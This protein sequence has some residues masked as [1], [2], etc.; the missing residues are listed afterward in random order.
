MLETSEINV[1][2]LLLFQ[3]GAVI[4]G[5]VAE[6]VRALL[7][8]RGLPHPLVW[9]Q[10]F[11]GVRWKEL[12]LRLLPRPQEVSEFLTL[13]SRHI[14]A[15]SKKKTRCHSSPPAGTA[16]VWSESKGRTTKASSWTPDLATSWPPPTPA[17]TSTSPKRRT[18]LSSSNRRR[19]TRACRSPGSTTPPRGCPC[20]ASSPAWVRPKARGRKERCLQKEQLIRKQ[21]EERGKVVLVWA[22]WW[23]QGLLHSHGAFLSAEQWLPCWCVM[24]SLTVEHDGYFFYLADIIVLCFFFFNLLKLI[25]P[26]H[27]VS[28]HEASHIWFCCHWQCSATPQLPSDMWAVWLINDIYRVSDICMCLYDT[29]YKYVGMLCDK[30]SCCFCTFLNKNMFQTYHFIRF[31]ITF[32]SASW[33]AGKQC[34]AWTTWYII[35]QICNLMYV[36]HHRDLF[37]DKY[38]KSFLLACYWWSIESFV[39]QKAIH[40][41]LKVKLLRLER[42]VGM[43]WTKVLKSFSIFKRMCTALQ[44]P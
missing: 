10:V 21:R 28:L 27:L 18:R 13:R 7:W 24:L 25:R 38:N 26:L 15:K 34:C 12:H 33:T 19:S 1:I 3:G 30:Y 20:T 36:I 42:I 6:D 16:C 8:K 29:V 9:Q 17:T 14:G 2:I 23:L 4:T 44:E 5:A 41:L 39:L 31:L 40:L 11:W 32:C 35:L 43:F 22:H 37:I